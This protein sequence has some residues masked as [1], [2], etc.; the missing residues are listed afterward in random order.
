MAKDLLYINPTL[1]N[2]Y[3]KNLEK[4]LDNKLKEIDI[5]MEASMQE[6]VTV[7]KQKAPVALKNGGRLRSSIGYIKDRPFSYALVAR[8]RYAAYVEFGTGKYALKYVKGLEE[9][10]RNVADR[11]YKNGK[12]KTKQKPFFY[13]AVNTVLPV[14]F[15]RIR[16]IL[17][18]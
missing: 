12:G 14:M 6:M 16:Q 7:A 9:Y 17:K 15:N 8:T 5:E 2:K 3:I 1:F 11:Y 4:K 18:K 13:P 10:W